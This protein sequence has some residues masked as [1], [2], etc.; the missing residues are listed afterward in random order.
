MAHFTNAQLAQS[1]S[2][3]IADDVVIKDQLRSWLAGVVGG[4]PNSDGKYP[5]TDYQGTIITI[6]SPAQM[7]DNVTGAVADAETAQ[8]AAE[9]AQTAAELA[10][11]NAQ[12]SE[13][14]A[15]TAE[16]GSVAAKDTAVSAASDA[17]SS[18]S[19]AIAQAAA[20]VVSADAAEVSNVAAESSETDAQ[21]SED[22][23]AT[24]E[25]NAAASEAK[26]ED[27]A[28]EVEDTPVETGPD[29]FSAL[30]WAA[31]AAATAAAI[32]DLDSLSDVTVAAPADKHAL[33]YDGVSDF[34]NR[35]LVE[36]DISNLGATILLDSD[37]G[38][39]VQA[40]DA[41]TVKADVAETIAAL[42]T[43]SGRVKMTADAVGGGQG[44]SLV[45]FAPNPQFTIEYTGG[46]ADAKVWNHIASTNFYKLRLLSDNYGSSADFLTLTRSGMTP[47][48]L[49]VNAAISATGD[50]TGAN[51]NIATWDAAEPGDATILKDA[52]I[53]VN[54]QAFDAN[55]ATT[56]TNWSAAD[57]TSGTLAVG[58]G[59]TGVTGSTGTGN[60]VR[61]AS[62][63]FS[64][65]ITVAG[66]VTAQTLSADVVGANNDPGTDNAFFTGFGFIGNRATCYLTN[67]N[68]TGRVVIGVNGIHNANVVAAFN[69]SGLN[70]ELG[71]I[72][73][74]ALAVPAYITTGYT[75]G[76]ISVSS[77]EPG[78]PAKG[79]IWFDTS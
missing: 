32:G 75:S 2:D 41:D 45:I 67:A 40:F 28:V 59:G 46:G 55:N 49:A 66:D 20:A 14:D 18:E 12:S 73:V 36:A 7:A 56:A 48:S 38:G 44:S 58:R 22:N 10:E 9:T 8:A 5:L 17:A 3:L 43:H 39:S 24:S 61:S 63:T 57:I 50:I 52:D 51:L 16:T 60:T 21:T 13:D 29:E 54:V 68:A 27:W 23:A 26:A 71:T 4:G 78:S 34:I 11:T 30:H 70:M 19:V 77:S 72:K 69:A 64:G 74:N 25:T 47:T 79:D 42:W 62:P 31:K 6:E 53:G 15:T 65:G 1:I 76:K 33:M 35:V 37:I